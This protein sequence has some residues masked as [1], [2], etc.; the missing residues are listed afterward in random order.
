MLNRLWKSRLSLRQSV[1]SL[2]QPQ[3]NSANIFSHEQ[4]DEAQ[5]P[6]HRLPERHPELELP[7]LR[8]STI[9]QGRKKAMAIPMQSQ[10]LQAGITMVHPMEASKQAAKAGRDTQGYDGGTSSGS[11]EPSSGLRP[12]VAGA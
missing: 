10:R 4:Q 7:F 11:L 3:A 2:A 6:F 9:D 1:S 8:S 12:A 5:L